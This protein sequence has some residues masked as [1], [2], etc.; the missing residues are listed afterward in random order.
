MVKKKFFEKMDES[1]INEEIAGE[2]MDENGDVHPAER[3]VQNMYTDHLQWLVAEKY[4]VLDGRIEVEDVGEYRVYDPLEDSDLFGSFIGIGGDQRELEFEKRIKAWVEDHGLLT[5]SRGTE[6][7]GSSRGA[8]NI[9]QDPISLEDF[10]REVQEARSATELYHLLYAGDKSAMVERADKLD[11]DARR[12]RELDRVEKLL[13]PY[14]QEERNSSSENK[15]QMIVVGFEVF[16]QKKI[17]EVR[18]SLSAPSGWNFPGERYSP[19][20]SYRCPDLLSAIWLKF[21][22]AITERHPMRRCKNPRCRELYFLRRSDQEYCTPRCRSSGRPSR[23][24]HNGT[25]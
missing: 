24:K 17:S 11:Q 19:I 10:Q 15:T 5:G 13:S 14:S 2:W 6:I 9:E 23:Q 22:L 4:R 18:L 8:K 1:F 12:E 25:G 7:T 16:L 3:I 21:Y 20:R